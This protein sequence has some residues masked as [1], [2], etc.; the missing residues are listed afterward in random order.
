MGPQEQW[1]SV[2]VCF[3]LTEHSATPRQG[4][5]QEWYV[6][7]YRKKDWT[8][9]Q[10]TTHRTHCKLSADW[11]LI[12]Y[13]FS[14]WQFGSTMLKHK[15]NIPS[16]SYTPVNTICSLIP[17]GAHNTIPGWVVVYYL[18]PMRSLIDDV[19]SVWRTIPSVD[20]RYSFRRS[21]RTIW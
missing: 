6:V 8:S 1:G 4:Q 20:P 11:L 9:Q 15:L 14:V 16:C 13:N 18:E 21:S 12:R 5:A 7:L 10:L 2:Q 17:A 19:C 3:L